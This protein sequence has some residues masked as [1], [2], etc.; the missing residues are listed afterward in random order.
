MTFDSVLE[1]GLTIVGSGGI[2]AAITY[3]G[4]Y[5]SR[6]RVESELAKQAEIATK[7]QHGIMEKDRF[8]AMYKQITD[9][10]NDYNDLSDQFREYRKNARAIETEFDEKL[11]TKSNELASLKDQVHYLKRLRC[12]DLECPKRIKD[13]PNTKK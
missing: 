3:F 2:G 13:N 9:M 5:K 6:K 1:W 12:Y 8:E 4:N 11:R 10:A 7:N